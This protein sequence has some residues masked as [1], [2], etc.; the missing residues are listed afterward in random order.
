MLKLWTALSVALAPVALSAALPLVENVEFQPL[1]AQ[2]KRIVEASD[3]LGSPLAKEDRAAIEKAATAAELQ[4]VLDKYCL[5]GVHINPE[6][7][8]KV[9][10]G[11][12]KPAL[13]EQG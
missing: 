6:M 4:R 3:Y 7:R 11:D 12:A 8:V 2:A 9:A 13:V 10:T 1:A 5:F